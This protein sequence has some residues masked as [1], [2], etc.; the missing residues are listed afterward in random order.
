[1]CQ[2]LTAQGAAAQCWSL[3]LARGL[4]F[5]IENKAS[6]INMSLGGPPGSEEKILKRMI[7]EAVSRGSLVVAAAGNDGADGKPGFPA[8]LSSVVAVTAVDSK[9]Q[10]SSSA[11]QGDFVDLAAPGVEI[12]STSPGGKVLVSSG[13]SLAAAFVSGAAA[14]ALQQQPRLSPAA[15]QALLE[16]TAKDLGP[17]GR[18]RQFGYGRV[19]AR[20][21]E[22][23]VGKETSTSV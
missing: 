10:L 11:T 13:T 7:E 4:D 8:A 20:S 21:E 17:H 2:P 5:A 19:D 1:S 15:I 9:D 23:R 22:R 3:S 14:L 16:R 18:D 6:V 12:L